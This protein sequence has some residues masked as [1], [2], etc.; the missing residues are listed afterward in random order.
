MKKVLIIATIMIAAG[1][2]YTVPK[3]IGGARAYVFGYPLVV[4]ELTR[5]GMVE[6]E[7]VNRFNHNQ[8]FPDHTFREVVRPN[9]DT[10]YSSAWLDLTDGPLQLDTP[11]T[12]GRY[13]VIPLMDAWTNVFASIGK[14]TRGTG[15]ASYLLAGPD[16]QGDAPTGMELV[17]AP[18]N[19][20]WVIGRIQ[21]NGPDDVAS[22]GVLQQGFRLVPL[23]NPAPSAHLAKKAAPL[24]PT[25]A[26]LDPYA[27]IEN[28]PAADFLQLLA[29]LMAEQPATTRDAPY[30]QQLVGIGLLAGQRY[31]IER[32]SSLD[33]WLLD[34]GKRLAH[35]G[36]RKALDS[37]TPENG[38]RVA[39]SGIGNYGI[40]YGTRTGVAMIGLG[41]LPPE[42]AIYPNAISDA[43][44]QPLSG[45][46]R[47]RIHFPPGQTPPVD[48]FWSLTMYDANG[49]LV[50]NP[51]D[52]YT[53]G[54]RDTLVFNEDGSL[55]VLIQ[56]DAPL[57]SQDNW[58]P[59]P[60]GEFAVTMR[61]YL[62]RDTVLDGS[63]R[64]PGIERL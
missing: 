41:A 62:P 37:R 50:E 59:A 54:D 4:M 49:F 18:T 17:R 19:M 39:R 40:D 58:L 53:L 35:A 38:W 16:W 7:G 46:H 36:V 52:R 26:G 33:A 25:N 51:I 2:F 22:V 30:L 1:A 57:G 48:A 24:S 5:R 23:D 34:T 56:H 47:Y 27:Q 43:Q 31:E 12:A 42:E 8:V 15:A 32:L 10:L 14:R 63:W 21:T 64:V 29:Q 9:T 61:L 20:V 44:G 28:M 55:D 60:A 45:E 11:D 3:V 13:F 6:A